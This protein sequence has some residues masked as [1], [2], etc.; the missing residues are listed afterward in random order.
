MTIRKYIVITIAILYSVLGQS[1]NLSVKSFRLLDFDLTAITEGT[2]VMDQNGEKAALIKV[3]TTQHGFTFDCGVLGIVK[4]EQKPGEIW[5][6]V[7][8][9]IKKLSI[10]HPEYGIIRDYYLDI[11]IKSGLTYELT[12]N[13]PKDA[14]APLSDFKDFYD[15]IYAIKISNIIVEYNGKKYDPEIDVK[16]QLVGTGFMVEGNFV[17]SRIVVQPWLYGNAQHDDWRSLLAQYVSLGFMVSI[18]FDAYTLSNK[19]KPIHFCNLDFLIPT[20]QFQERTLKLHESIYNKV[21]NW[22]IELPSYKYVSKNRTQQYLEDP[23]YAILPLNGAASLPILANIN[24][25][26]KTGD[27]VIVAG[28]TGTYS[29]ADILLNIQYATRNISKFDKDYIALNSP[30]EHWGLVGAP[31]MF[32][33]DGQYYVIGMNAGNINGEDRVIPIPQLILRS[34]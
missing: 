6:Y 8:R 27:E 18:E 19:S 14:S 24:G 25:S 7:P 10:M 31:V 5:I 17:T 26:L 15:D 22:G 2:I 32:N 30:Y 4:T 29:A 28:Y 34:R 3:V 16:G 20:G 12:L 21:K 11:P 33:A 23:S 1:Q 13:T 9:G